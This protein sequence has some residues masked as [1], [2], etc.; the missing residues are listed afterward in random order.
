MSTPSVA[1]SGPTAADKVTPAAWY[2]LV[3][4]SLTNLMS[5]LDR[6]ILAILAPSIKADLGIGD[7]ELGLL[8]GTVFALFYALFSLPIGRLADGWVR[9]KLLAIA[10]AIWSLATGLAGFAQGFALLSLSRLGVGIGEGATAPAGTSLLFDY[11][12]PRRRGLVMAVVAASIAIGLGASSVIGGVAA[13]WWDVRYPAAATAPLGLAGWQFA[14]V[15]ACLPGFV[16]AILLWRMLE[17]PRGAMDGIVSPPDLHPFRASLGVL[18]TVLPGS[19]WV[20]LWRRR[21]SARDW[22]TNLGGLLLI[23]VVMVLA[24]RWASVF[25]PRP[26]LD[27]GALRV[28]P[29]ALQW[30]VVGF[31]LYVTLNLLQGLRLSDRPVFAVLVRSPSVAIALSAAALQMIINYGVMGFTPSFI[32][33]NYQQSL[34]DTALVFGTLA[35]AIGILGPMISGPL[36]DNLNQRFGNRGRVA[37]TLFALGVSPFIAFWV[38]NAPD[39][40]SFYFRFVFYSLVLTQWLPPLYACL[41]DLVLPRMRGITASTYTIVSTITGLGIGPYAV[42]MVSDARGG[43]LTFAILSVNVVAPVLVVLLVVLLFRVGRD[44]DM[45]VARARAAGE[46]FE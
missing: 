33:K 32:M 6:N 34:T 13:D 9:R 20:A 39:V 44:R 25:S 10:I 40:Y 2:A 42:G 12:P 29:H 28:N 11:F 35:G 36:S 23:I 41:Y 1:E 43:D 30:S 4:V 3:L 31:G 18:G 14:F 38:Y 5:L 45:M 37:V 7:A 15:V 19:N 21:A 46:H 27:L 8:Y 24:T 17:P 16:L 22:I 26:R